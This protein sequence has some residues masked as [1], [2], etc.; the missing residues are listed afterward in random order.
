[1]EA[2]YI[3]F[4][5]GARVCLGKVFANAEVKLLT[6]AVVLNFEL[7]R[8]ELSDTND[9]SMVQMG[10]QNALPLGLKCEIHF[11]RV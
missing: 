3:P 6:T 11:Q 2:Y 4:G 10:T 1:M 8:D 5:Y 9:A 7:S